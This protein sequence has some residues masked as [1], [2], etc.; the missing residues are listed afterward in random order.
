MCN[1][2]HP[3]KNYV[4]LWRVAPQSTTIYLPTK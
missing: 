2:A 3:N 1:L 4:S